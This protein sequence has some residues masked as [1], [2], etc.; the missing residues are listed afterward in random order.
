MAENVVLRVINFDWLSKLITNSNDGS[1]LKLE[2]HTFACC[3]LRGCGV[4]IDLAFWSSDWGAV[5][6]DG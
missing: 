1:H 5:E 3:E 6:D 2:I 4:G